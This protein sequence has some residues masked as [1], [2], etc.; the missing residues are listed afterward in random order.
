ML[1]ELLGLR[2]ILLNLLF[3]VAKG[4]TMT[5]E[6]MQALIE[7]RPTPARWSGRGSCWRPRH[8]PDSPESRQRKGAVMSHWGRKI[9]QSWPSRHP[10]W[11][12]AA[13]FGAVVFFA[14]CAFHAVRAGLVICRKVLSPGSC[15]KS[16]V[17][18][19]VPESGHAIPPH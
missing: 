17:D 5:A 18:W 4:E 2:A 13:L 8:A 1:A 19:D 6:Q 16:S 3:K 9:Y 10:V 15:T 11:T 7:R 12:L 14:A